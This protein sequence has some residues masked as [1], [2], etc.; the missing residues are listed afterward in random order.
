M[1]RTLVLAIAMFMVSSTAMGVTQ[2][3]S[4]NLNSS[5][6]TLFYPDDENRGFKDAHPP[7]DAVLDALLA[8]PEVKD[9]VDEMSDHKRDI[10]REAIRK[11]FE[12]VPVELS[13][14]NEKSYVV[15]GKFPMSGGDCDW[16][17]IV[18][19]GSK[20][21]KVIL[22]A[23]GLS[24][25]L[26]RTKTHGYRDIRGTWGTAADHGYLMYRYHGPSYNKGYEDV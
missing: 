12:T 7:S 26:Q 8:T 23:A 10:S 21:A 16:F 22:Y 24:L 6:H 25:E 14:A 13:D 3:K 20:S 18:R 5:E 19:T 2:R 4:A 1:A 9:T 15:V 17:W 11:L